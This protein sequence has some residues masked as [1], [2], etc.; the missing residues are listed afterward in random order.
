MVLLEIFCL[1]L[2][3]KDPLGIQIMDTQ[4]IAVL[5]NRIKEAQGF[6][7]PANKL[8][9]YH[10]EL[11]DDEDLVKKVEGLQ[12]NEK[13]PLK[14]TYRLAEVFNNNL[15]EHT[16]HILVQLPSRKSCD[17]GPPPV[18]SGCLG[19]HSTHWVTNIFLY[20]KCH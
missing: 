13:H 9:L 17:S 18:L 16:V 2:G 19:G 7:F 14:A 8:M 6:I 20:A 4:S 5:K 15:K 12:L 1:V 10:V 3:D 11:D